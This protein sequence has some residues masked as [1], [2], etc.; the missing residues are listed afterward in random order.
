[1]RCRCNELA[2]AII[3]TLLR[4][5]TAVSPSAAVFSRS[6][7]QRPATTPD[8]FFWGGVPRCF[9]LGPGSSRAWQGARARSHQRTDARG[10]GIFDVAQA[11]TVPPLLRS[12][13]STGAEQEDH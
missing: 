2:A 11:L 9:G 12:W 7:L 8:V 1:M 4:R 10:R 6:S 13:G 5:V 3:L